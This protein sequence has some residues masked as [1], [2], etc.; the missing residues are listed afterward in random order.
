MQGGDHG[1]MTAR[2]INISLATDGIVI[3]VKRSNTIRFVFQ[4]EE[5]HIVY[6]HPMRAKDIDIKKQWLS[7]EVG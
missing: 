4:K 6:L 7:S 5:V 2:N 3:S 1:R